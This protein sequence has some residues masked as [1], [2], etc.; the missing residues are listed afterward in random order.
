MT[1]ASQKLLL[2]EK[3]LSE[4]PEGIPNIFKRSN[5]DRYMERPSATFCN[6]K[7]R[8]L[9][10][11]CYTEFLAHYTLE[12][13]SNKTCEYQPDELDDNLIENNHEKCSYPQKIK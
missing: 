4:I 10:D 11:F 9:N 12:N 8:V 2:P 5:I 3:E 6:G 7:C 13:K 1:K